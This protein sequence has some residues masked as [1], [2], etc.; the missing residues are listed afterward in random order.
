MRRMH[1]RNPI[2]ASVRIPGSKSVTHRALCA[3]ALAEGKSLLRGAL[4]CE[5]TAYTLEALETLGAGMTRSADDILVSGNSGR[6][7]AIREKANLFLGNAG[8]A[9]RLLLSVASL[10]EREFLLDGSTR[11]RERPLGG[12]ADALNGLGARISFLGEK[13]YPPV[14]VEAHGLEGGVAVVSGKESSQ[15]VSSLLLAAPYA[16]KDTEIH[17]KGGLASRPY[18]DM[19]LKVMQAF[20]A[21]VSR[22][23][24]K[25]FFVESNRPYRPHE[26]IVEADVSSASYFWAAAA[27]TR[28]SMTTEN[29][30]P[31]STVQ[32]DI[33]FLDLLE[34][35]GCKVEREEGKV[36]IRGV[37][38]RGIEADMG[39]MPDMVPTLASLALFAEGETVIRNVAHLRLKESDRLRV[40]AHEWGRMGARVQELQDG[41]IIRGGQPLK[42][43]ILDPH[44]DHR[45]AMSLAVVGLKVP[46]IA[47]ID[48]G[49]VKKS[50]PGF[51]DLWRGLQ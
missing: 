6:V 9:M 42:G 46:R 48:D 27:V 12:L 44:N 7:R 43:A 21:H 30:D 47:I 24:Y 38:L 31:F 45:I 39:D 29:V 51:W 23:G 5:D 2:R 34:Q 1:P 4:F 19:T 40:I 41:L 16:R 3:A 50:F 17:V 8:T 18:V 15:Y 35:M 26:F 33:R 11:M 32:G 28:G 37:A 14:F 49:C 20:G 13:G 25:C 36:S 10:G 22:Q